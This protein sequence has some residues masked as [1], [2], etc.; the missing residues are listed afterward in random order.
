MSAAQSTT[1]FFGRAYSLTITPNQGPS[2]GTPIIVSSDA[3]EPAALKFSFDVVQMAFSAFWQ[4]EITIYNADGPISTGPSAGVNLYQAVIQ[5]GDIVTLAAGYQ[6]DYPFPS[7]PPAIFTGPIFYTIQ[8][9]IDVVD[10]RLIIHCLLNRVLTTQNFLNATIPALST[11]FSQAQF[12]ASKS[13]NKINLNESQLQLAIKSANPQRGAAQLPRGK[14]FFGNPHPYLT[15]LADQNSLL[16]WFDHK[17][18][19]V[20]SLQNPVG[21]LIATYA[22]VT[23]RGGPPL[24]IDG[25]TLSLI[26]QPQQTQLGVDFRVL[27]DPNVQI[28]SPL[29]QVAIQPEYIRQAP[30]SY[31][32]PV[33]TGPPVPI[34]SQYVVIGVRFR[35][36]TRGN[37]W[38]SDITGIAQ[39]QQAIQLLGQSLQADATGN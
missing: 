25:V 29:P 35:G 23:P 36:D 9:R 12:I 19:N 3:F 4:A 24:R 20:D 28:N 21:E 16:S 5:E 27:L 39:I 14:S 1:P 2:A 7:T 33:G 34:V 17:G 30:I 37:E 13:T 10:K 18:W 22:P 15:A 26:S 38:Y 8:D 32:L 6:A 11:Q 31:P